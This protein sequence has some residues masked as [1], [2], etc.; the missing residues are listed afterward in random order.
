MLSD[1]LG[2]LDQAQY[3]GFEEQHDYWPDILSKLMA[4]QVYNLA[5][6]EHLRRHHFKFLKSIKKKKNRIEHF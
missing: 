4:T 2:A 6:T 1:R 5:V 3:G